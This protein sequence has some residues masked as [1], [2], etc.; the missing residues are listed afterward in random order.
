MDAVGANTELLRP[1]VP[2]DCLET[3]LPS[4]GVETIQEFLNNLLW[5]MISISMQGWTRAMKI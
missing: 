5:R 1:G 4:A 3:Q 2:P